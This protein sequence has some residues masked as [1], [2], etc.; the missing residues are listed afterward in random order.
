MLSD[1]FAVHLAGVWRASS[2]EQPPGSPPVAAAKVDADPL[3]LQGRRVVIVEDEAIT[4]IQLR[5]ICLTAGMQVVGLAADGES[6]VRIALETHPDIVLMDIKMPVL[7]GLTAAER[8]L[9]EL[10]VCVVMLTAYDLEDYQQRA[11]AIGT[12]GYVL[13]PFTGAVLVPKLQA[14]YRVYQQRQ[15]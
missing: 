6:G 1:P 4:Q 15:P 3:I 5:K 13:K 12:C 14:A 7:D 10:S 8:I 9:R 11:K 2:N